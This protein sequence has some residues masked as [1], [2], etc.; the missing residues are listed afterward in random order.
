MTKL[1][2][3]LLTTAAL[4][5]L[6][7]AV[8][9]GASISIS[10]DASTLSAAPGGTVVFHGTIT[11]L[12]SV[13]VDLNGSVTTLAGQFTTDDGTLFFTNAPF[14]L[15]PNETSAPFDIFSV[16]VNSPYTGTFQPFPGVFSVVGGLEEAGGTTP[17]TN[18]GQV[19]FDVVAAPE[20]GTAGM[21]F[22][23]VPLVALEL[24]RRIN[25]GRV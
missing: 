16:T 21:L 6:S 19:V 11:N 24:R 1:R 13:I 3:L 23:S 17:D 10:L 5:I 18:L 9:R 4:A 25:R 8:A 14:T 12:A 15:N 7:G 22:L 20:P 2:N